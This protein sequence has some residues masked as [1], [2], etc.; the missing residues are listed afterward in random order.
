MGITCIVLFLIPN[1][2]ISE[3]L[4]KYYK[5]MLNA[6]KGKDIGEVANPQKG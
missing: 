3:E 1:H 2:F 5:K 6:K 4:Y